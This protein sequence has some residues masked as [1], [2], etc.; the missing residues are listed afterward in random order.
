MKTKRRSLTAASLFFAFCS[1]V[2]QAEYLQECSND[3][4]FQNL[5]YP[6]VTGEFVT[7]PGAFDGLSEGLWRRSVFRLQVD[8]FSIDFEEVCTPQGRIVCS[9]FEA[10][11]FIENDFMKN[12]R[13]LI[14]S[15]GTITRSSEETQL[16]LIV[17][18]SWI[19]NLLSA[20]GVS[21]EQRRDSNSLEFENT[22]V[23]VRYCK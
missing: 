5:E 7:S 12:G 20:R 6:N 10:G 22:L 19:L 2:A 11:T 21:I 3:E 17:P 16:V 23:F 18:K 15:R 4:V 9:L 14:R 13:Y 1:S 8:D